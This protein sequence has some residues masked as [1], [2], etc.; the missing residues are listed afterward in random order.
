MVRFSFEKVCAVSSYRF[1]YL[2]TASM[3]LVGYLTML[4]VSR[5]CSVDGRVI[6]GCGAFGG[7]R[8]GRGDRLVV[9]YY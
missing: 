4:S 5:Q 9:K 7:M 1:L 3:F 2:V 8:I 6:K